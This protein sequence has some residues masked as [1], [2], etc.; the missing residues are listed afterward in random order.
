M[1]S[2]KATL[3]C[4]ALSSRHMNDAA[5]QD[6]ARGLRGGINGLLHLRRK[7]IAMKGTRILLAFGSRHMTH[8][9]HQLTLDVGQERTS[10]GK[11]S[12]EGI[13]HVYLSVGFDAQ[14]VLADADTT[15][16]AGQTFIARL[17]VN[18]F[19]LLTLYYF[20]LFTF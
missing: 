15:S 7:L 20:H 16:K 3:G 18:L 5:R 10:F 4:A 13:E 14:V 1:H 9:H 11:Q 8:H 12:K 19:H 17:C 2:P 6:K